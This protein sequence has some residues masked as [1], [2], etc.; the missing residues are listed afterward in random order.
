MSLRSSHHD[1][2]AVA[3]TAAHHIVAGVPRLPMTATAGAGRALFA[4]RRFDC[5]EIVCLLDDEDRLQG[6]VPVTELIGLPDQ[7]PLA[8]VMHGRWPR[9]HPDVD[10]E[11]VASLALHHAMSAIAVVDRS[12]RLLGVVPGAALMRILRREHV[13]DL[14]RFAGIGRETLRAREAIEEPPL[15][16]ARDRLPWLIVG[17][18]GSMLATWVMSRFEAALAHTVAL[19]FF[20]PGIVYLADAIGTQTEAIAVRGLSLSHAG[21]GQLIGG[22][23]RTGLIIG[24]TLGAIT[25]PAVWLVFG[26][27]RLA[28]A[29]AG[30]LVC[31]GGIATTIGL[32]LPWLL[33]RIG[34]DPAYGSGPLA[35]IIQDVLSI[36]IYFATVSLVLG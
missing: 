34:A 15:R 19:A 26:D 20:V 18:A 11:R 35:T 9:V 28:A 29:V 24:L 7:T 12:G 6:V 27:W 32:A 16:R 5:A 22:E 14:H 36:L 17:L 8:T 13:E 33:G 31:A 30:S 25:L 1:S 4:G 2:G 10:Q 3:E 23:L 21:V